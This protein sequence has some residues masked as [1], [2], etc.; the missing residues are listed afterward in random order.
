MSLTIKDI[1]RLAGVSHTTVSKA[2]NNTGR[3]KEETRQKILKI[4]EQSNYIPNF[5]AKSLVTDKSYT[6]G[7]FSIK[8]KII[9]STF[10]DIIEGIQEISG[11]TYNLVFRKFES[12]YEL[13]K[14]LKHRKY[15]GIIF[16]SIINDDIKYIQLIASQKLPLIVINRRMNDSAIYNVVADD[17]GGAFKAT[18]HL[19]KLG[20]A[21]IAYVEGPSDNIVATERRSGYLDALKKYNTPVN[22]DYI[23]KSNGLPDG[24][25]LAMNNLLTLA[26]RPTAVF[27]YSDP[28]ATGVIKAIWKKGLKIPNDIAVVGFDNMVSSQYLVPSLT[29][30]DKPR[31]DMGKSA[32]VLLLK[33][34][35]N[36]EG[37]S[38]SRFVQ[39]ET[40]LIIRE[41]CG[42]LNVNT[43]F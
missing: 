30:I 20:H 13:N 37:S 14:I 3:M 18:E 12:E 39:I 4:A 2:L 41:S 17:R 40:R 9:S 22:A 6:I 1:S 38:Y 35:N 28:V 32:A 23:V 21:G 26:K 43:H 16:I 8:E 27:V 29:S 31:F 42:A 15:D 11:L 19:L 10:Y 34:L 33:V 5:S 25:Y 36:E 24:G 7:V